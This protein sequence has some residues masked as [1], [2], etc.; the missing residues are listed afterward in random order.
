MASLR[1]FARKVAADNETWRNNNQTWARANFSFFLYFLF[2]IKWHFEFFF[3]EKWG[4]DI[5]PI[6]PPCIRPWDVLS[7]ANFPTHAFLNINIFEV[8]LFETMSA[9]KN[10]KYINQNLKLGEWIKT[11]KIFVAFFFPL[12][13]LIH[14]FYVRTSLVFPY[15]LHKIVSSPFLPS[16]FL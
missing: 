1:T 5:H 10:A 12:F 11:W 2:Q 6:H 13:L 4:V 7:L 14:I 3:T 16:F 9:P 15:L 8:V